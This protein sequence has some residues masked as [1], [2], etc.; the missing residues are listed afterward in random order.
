MASD[1]GGDVPGTDAT[2]VTMHV[3]AIPRRKPRRHRRQRGF[4]RSGRDARAGRDAGR[5]NARTAT[6]SRPSTSTSS[7]M[8]ARSRS[9]KRRK[10]TATASASR[11]TERRSDPGV[12]IGGFAAVGIVE[13]DSIGDERELVVNDASVW[14]LPMTDG[15][16]CSAARRAPS[17]PGAGC[18]CT[19]RGKTVRAVGS[20][21][22]ARWRSAWPGMP[23]DAFDAAS[24]GS[25]LSVRATRRSATSTR[26]STERSTSA[27][28]RR[29]AADP[30]E[31]PRSRT[32][33]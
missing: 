10:A 29:P 25:A 13:C 21:A 8:T 16:R 22:V 23:S 28:R 12:P 6:G 24:G 17:G 3:V 27:R 7:S 4:R 2:G 26:S 32:R 20:E 31:R 14:L 11:R 18:S 33:R 19:R 15:S 5:R 1:I 30:A 9:G